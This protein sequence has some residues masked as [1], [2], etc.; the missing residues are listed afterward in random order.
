MKPLPEAPDMQSF[1]ASLPFPPWLTGFA[2]GVFAG[3]TVTILH[4]L[5]VPKRFPRPR[6]RS[7]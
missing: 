1:F 7:E 4:D 6:E 5:F 3:V 2:L